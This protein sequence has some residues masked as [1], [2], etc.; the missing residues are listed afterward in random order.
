MENFKLIISTPEKMFFSE[1]VESLI[2]QTPEGE[3]GV[4]PNHLTMVVAL[5]TAPVKIKKDGSWR[6]AAIT[7]AFAQIKPKQ[8]V[9]LADSAEW[10][11]DIEVNRAMEA[12]KRAEERLQTHLSKIEYVQSQVALR[13]AMTRLSV[14][15]NK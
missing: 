12:K 13:R 7:G 9:I 6:E 10:P 5:E 14:V 1:D 2:F 4:L 3:M 8:V 11:E 15:K